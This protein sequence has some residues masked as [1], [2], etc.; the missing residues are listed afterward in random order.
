MKNNF[1]PILLIPEYFRNIS[2]LEPQLP[3]I[4]KKP[5]KP[6]LNEPQK[7]EK[8]KF[9]E[10]N[11]LGCVFIAIIVL[12]L[13]ISIGFIGEVSKIFLEMLEGAIVL[14]IMLLIAPFFGIVQTAK[15]YSKKNKNDND[16][17][18]KVK[19]YEQNLLDYDK[20]K[21]RYPN[22]LKKYNEV[23][24]PN[25]Q[26]QLQVYEEQKYYIL[27]QNNVLNY[28]KEQIRK[29]FHSHVK[30][31][32]IDSVY[33]TG[34]SE[35]VFFT[36]LQSKSPNFK[37]GFGIKK[38][39]ESKNYEPDIVYLDTYSGIVIDIEIDE[40]YN[41]ADGTPLHYI[42]LDNKRNQ[43]FKMNGWVVIRFA[44]VQ[45]V[46]YPEKCFDFLMFV[47]SELSKGCVN[48]ENNYLD[49]IAQWTKDE[50]YE[51]AYRRFRKTY[52]K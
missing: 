6:E 34:A 12:V 28:R 36:F 25:Y 4:P 44:E 18:I 40:P 2:H 15:Y 39:I 1:Y 11:P 8:E 43:F 49:N 42:D 9:D 27:S 31:D 21:L 33:S 13:I 46:K 38:E 51:M 19:K 48:I 23:E 3:E 32:K 24:L 17:L 35:N 26:K 30:V 7:P 52:I 45:V 10:K 16:Y 20:Y 22:E 50:A 37:R 47:I 5:I 14:F 41:I 29:H